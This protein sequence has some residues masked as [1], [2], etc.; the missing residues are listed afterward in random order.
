LRL[1]E[2]AVKGGGT[3]V[4]GHRQRVLQEVQLVPDGREL[5]LV[6]VAEAVEAINGLEREVQE[7]ALDREVV[8][9]ELRADPE[10]LGPEDGLCGQ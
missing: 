10:R 3:G 8:F 1:G 7:P 2:V 5:I 4:L 6:D 9:A